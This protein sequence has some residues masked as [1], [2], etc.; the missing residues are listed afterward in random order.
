V[1]MDSAAM[2]NH[3]SSGQ[4]TVFNIVNGVNATL[5]G[6]DFLSLECRVRCGSHFL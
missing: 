6:S 5:A 1:V 3:A 4:G 2:V